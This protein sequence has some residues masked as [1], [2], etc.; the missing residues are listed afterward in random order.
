MLGAPRRV[1][2]LDVAP[3]CADAQAAP[4]AASQ[5]HALTIKYNH[6]LRPLKAVHDL[7]DPV[8]AF[9]LAVGL[10]A[11]VRHS[12]AA[13]LA[14][15]HYLPGAH[16]THA[17]ARLARRANLGATGASLAASWAAAHPALSRA[18]LSALL[19]AV[20]PGAPTRGV[21]AATAPAVLAKL[22]LAAQRAPM[23]A[24]LLLLQPNART[25]LAEHYGPLTRNEWRG[26]TAARLATTRG[27][28][29]TPAVLYAH[30]ARSTDEASR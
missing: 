2:R 22:P 8:T 29:C 23:H 26:V 13:L 4:A 25:L 10:P 12:D 20:H 15:A 1:A 21:L 9:S 28:L 14:L 30:L 18:T 24:A 11:G 16:K 5:V 7:A 27:E 3:K 17:Y 19:G 6:L